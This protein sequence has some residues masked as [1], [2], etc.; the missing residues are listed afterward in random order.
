MLLMLVN[1]DPSNSAQTTVNLANYAPAS[2]AAVYQYSSANLGAIQHLSDIAV[3][4]QFAVSLPAYSITLLV[5]S[6]GRL[7]RQGSPTPGTPTATPTAVGNRQSRI[8]PTAVAVGTATPTPTSVSGRPHRTAAR[9]ANGEGR[10]VDQFDRWH[11]YG[12]RMIAHPPGG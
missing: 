6:H 4:N 3:G 8:T 10:P 5:L 11:V 7:A 2:A 1:Q 12:R 9:A